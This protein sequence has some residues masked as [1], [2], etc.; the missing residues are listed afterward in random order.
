MESAMAML[1]G[2][3]AGEEE[4]EAAMAGGYNK[5]ASQRAPAQPGAGMMFDE[6]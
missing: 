2:P 1:R 5:V 4:M 6:E 3:G